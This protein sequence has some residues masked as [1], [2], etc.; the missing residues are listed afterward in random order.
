MSAQGMT[1]DAS[2]SSSS[3]EVARR[4]LKR[5]TGAADHVDAEAAAATL[6][7][8]CTRISDSLRDTLGEDG[9]VA[10]FARAVA[11]AEMADP[12]LRT[13]R[14]VNG[15]G[16]SADGLRESIR[17]HGVAA[18]TAAVEAVLAAIVE[19]LSRLIGEDM[20]ARL[21]DHEGLPS[22]RKR[23]GETS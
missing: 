9:W 7:R 17:T 6:L 21:I 18:V 16:I 3:R 12:L 4:L 14:I 22:Q 1:D 23:R 2:R 15:R 8:V 10:L 13:G 11:R 19:V 5:D 20:A